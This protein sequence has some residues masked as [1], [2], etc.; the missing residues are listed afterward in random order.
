MKQ[1]EMAFLG[2]KPPLLFL[3]F[4]VGK[5]PFGTNGASLGPSDL[6]LPFVPLPL[7]DEEELEKNETGEKSLFK[8][9]IFTGVLKTNLGIP[10]RVCGL[11]L[12]Q[13]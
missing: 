1:R 9:S 10:K 4:K 5:L 12:F 13:G 6:L 2:G 7:E 11:F 8:K 3:S